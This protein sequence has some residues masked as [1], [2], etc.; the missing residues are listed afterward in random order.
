[1]EV[2]A[3]VITFS[4]CEGAGETFQIAGSEQFFGSTAHLTVSS[5][6][7]GEIA[8][9]ASSRI[10]TFGP[11]FRAEKHNTTRH[12]SEFW[13]LEP[14]ISF[15]DS[16]EQLMFSIEDLIIS[17][18][19]SLLNS[20]KEDLELVG[21]LQENSPELEQR[22]EMITKPYSRLSYTDAVAELTKFN[23]NFSSPL[24]WGDSLQLEHEKF[25]VDTVVKGPVFVADYPAG[26]KAFYMKMN[27]DNRTV[28]CCDLLV[29]GLAELVGGSLREEKADRLRRRMTDLGMQVDMYS[30]YL[31][32]RRYGGV[33]HG[34]FG[35]GFERFLQYITGVQNI[36][37]VC[38]IPRYRGNDRF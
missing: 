30:W 31:D 13:M 9:N 36:R 10:Y 16:L 19:N 1:M 18:T 17:S 38:M 6:L 22:W 11:T 26:I 7:H 27:P 4:D 29:P 34:G 2:H 8:S 35:L 12:L 24:K 25:L 21:R 32:L 3:P 23:S 15:I 28:A 33:P 20:A 14:E 37:D 5:Q